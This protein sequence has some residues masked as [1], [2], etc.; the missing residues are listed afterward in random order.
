MVKLTP[1]F[2]R[3]EAIS[4]VIS[5]PES[6]Q[7]K[8]GNHFYTFVDLPSSEEAD[9]AIKALNG[10]LAFGGRLRV[11][12]SRSV[13]RKVGERVEWQEEARLKEAGFG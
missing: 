13:P 5:P 10:K 1:P 2:T 9:A 12:N 6:I 4:K 7:L 8:P 3:S 11:H